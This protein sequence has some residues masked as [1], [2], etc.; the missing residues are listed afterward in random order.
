MPT[1][2]FLDKLN[3]T[4]SPNARLRWVCDH[5]FGRDRVARYELGNGLTVLLLVDRSAP[6]VS[7]AT[8]YRV[9]SRHEK[10]GK[11]GL[12]HFFEHL[13]FN[14][15]EHLAAGEFD[16]KLE[17]SGAESNA[18]TWLDWTY[19]YEA[20]PSE[21]VGLAI[22]IEADRMAHLV[23][24]QPQIDSER[25]VVSNERRMRVDD[26]PDGTANEML[27]KLAYTKHSYHWPTIGWMEDIAAYTPADCE[28]FYRAYY[29]PNNATVVIVGDIK[30]QSVLAKL[31]LAYG[32][33]P[34]SVVP[35]EDIVPEPPQLEPR[36]LTVLK[37]TTNE[38]I[39]VGYMGPS[40]GDHDHTPL[41]VL[42]EVMS[43]GRASRLYTTLVTEREVASEPRC[44]AA[45]FRDPGIFEIT[46][47]AREGHTAREIE[48]LI[49]SEI[50]KLSSELIS[51][52]ELERAKA[53]LELNQ[54]QSLETA[55][56]KAEQIG[57]YETVLGDPSAAFARLDATR[58]VKR[59]DIRRVARRY[60]VERARNTVYLLPEVTHA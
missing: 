1:P 48:Q 43:G 51:E 47:T 52:E 22:Q 40:L 19:Y 55:N 18:A 57:F 3:A 16:R 8:W 13:M 5:P 10:P 23:L 53:R 25:E 37:P 56:G 44:W 30:P 20:L 54:V 14:E 49:V 11:T 33:I 6:V 29:A 4:A 36:T 24:R 46:A 26:D 59:E 35:A 42:A 50:D 31:Q 12:A 38:K 32:E 60:L 21:R 28:A 9:G 41:N 27:Y 7:Y 17:E 15:T 2:A 39:F 34:P 45:T 58:K